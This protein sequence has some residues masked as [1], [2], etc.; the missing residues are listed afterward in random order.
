MNGDPALGTGK[1]KIRLLSYANFSHSKRASRAISKLI[2]LAQKP[3]VLIKLLMWLIKIGW[4]LS[5]EMLTEIL[6]MEKPT[7]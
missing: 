6:T 7:T 5:L 4:Y 2:R 3:R 1:K